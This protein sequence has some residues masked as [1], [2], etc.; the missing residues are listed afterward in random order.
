MDTLKLDTPHAK[1]HC[2]DSTIWLLPLDE[3]EAFLAAW[4][5]GRAFWLGA[6]MYG[7]RIT[8]KLADIVG[9]S[10]WD[11]AALADSEHEQALRKARAMIDGEDE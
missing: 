5:A 4:T 3:H 8:I 1:A 11:A 10:V 7:E 2:R 6:G 9:L